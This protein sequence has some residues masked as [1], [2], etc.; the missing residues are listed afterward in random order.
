VA[1]T[2]AVSAERDQIVQLI[3]AQLAPTPH[4]MDVKVLHRAAPLTPPA[5]SFKHSLPDNFILSLSQFE[6]GLLLAERC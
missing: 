3:A 5:I 1:F 2:V 6:P 4:V